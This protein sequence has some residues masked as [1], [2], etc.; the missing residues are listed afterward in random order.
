MPLLTPLLSK[1]IAICFILVQ[2]SHQIIVTG[3]GGATNLKGG[4]VNALEGGV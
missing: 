4:G 1:L 2:T 3:K